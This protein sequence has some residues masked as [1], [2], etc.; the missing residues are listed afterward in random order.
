MTQITG[1]LKNTGW[2]KTNHG[3]ADANKQLKG[4]KIV[5]RYMTGIQMLK[6]QYKPSICFKQTVYKV[7]NTCTRCS[8]NFGFTNPAFT[9][10]AMGA[11]YH[12]YLLSEK[13]EPSNMKTG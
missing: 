8:D 4:V 7:L 10:F 1:F 9:L 5:I 2:T 13:S 11:L 12:L 3:Q 6:L